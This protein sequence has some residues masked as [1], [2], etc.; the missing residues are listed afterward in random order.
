M[1]ARNLEDV[2]RQRGD[3]VGLL[4][5]SKIGMYV[6]PV[7]AAEFT[8]W[9]DEQ[10]A[11]RDS[12]VLFAPSSRSASSYAIPVLP[13]RCWRHIRYSRRH[14]CGCRPRSVP[15]PGSTTPRENAGRG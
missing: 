15:E 14:R 5:N 3:T 13:A 7:V 6:Y 10:R 12:A 11:W 8:N 1:G 9:R 4:R 2:L